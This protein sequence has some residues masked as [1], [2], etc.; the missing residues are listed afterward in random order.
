MKRTPT[1]N[2]YSSGH[3]WYYFLGGAVLSPRQIQEAVRQ[4]GYQGYL[5]DEIALAAKK[6]EPKRSQSLRVL[7][8]RAVSELKRDLSGYRRRALELHRHRAIN[9]TPEQPV[10]CDD[11]HTNISLKHNHLTNDFAHLTYLDALLNQQGDLFG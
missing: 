9:T 7:R 4:S 3:P 8:A 5:G 11:I 10:S 6:S 2:D 1:H